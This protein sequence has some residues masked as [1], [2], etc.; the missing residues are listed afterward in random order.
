MCQ[1]LRITEYP[2]FQSMFVCFSPPEF[3]V[4]FLNARSGNFRFY[5]QFYEQFYEHF[6]EQ[7]CILFIATLFVRCFCSMCLALT[8][9]FNRLYNNLTFLVT[10]SVP[11]KSTGSTQYG[12]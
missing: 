4:R 1:D 3:F 6:Y 12:L 8:S 11:S 5:E 2:A 7:F 9:Q 10:S